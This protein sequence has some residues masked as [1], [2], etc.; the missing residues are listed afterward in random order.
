ML[1]FCEPDLDHIRSLR[2][3]LLCFEAVF[4]LKVNL[5]KSEIVQVGAVDNLS[6][7]ADFLGCKVSSLPMKYLDLPLGLLHK[8][9]VMWD[10]IVEKIECKLAGWKRL[11]LSKGG[12]ITLIKSTLSN[13]PTYILSLFPLSV[14]VAHRLEKTFCDFLWGSLEDVKKFH[15]IKWEK[16]CTPLSTGV[17]GFA[18]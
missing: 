12:R 5:S 17:L 8:S 2:A 1:I 14:G 4:G 18:T 9:K 13:L 3:L 16:V 6:D 10:E 11:H 15:L 7:L